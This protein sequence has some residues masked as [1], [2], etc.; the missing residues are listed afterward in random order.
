MRPLAARQAAGAASRSP[1][2]RSDALTAA[3]APVRPHSGRSAAL[4]AASA[5]VLPDSGRSDPLSRVTAPLRLLLLVLVALAGCA[6]AD[7]DPEV[8]RGE[9]LLWT[10]GCVA[11]HTLDGAPHVGPSLA[12]L[13]DER[14]EDYVLRAL[15]D[16]NI[17]LA[18]GFPPGLMPAYDLT[19][20][21][22]SALLAALAETRVPEQR[23]IVP[24][25]SACLLFLLLHLVLSARPIR[26][27]LVAR[28]GVYP[29]QGVYSAVVTALLAW[30][31][32]AWPDAPFVPLWDTPP[33]TRWVPLL[34][35]PFVL[36]GVIA[37]YTTPSPTVALM[38]GVVERPEP[39]RGAVKITRHPANLSMAAWGALH[40]VANGDLRSVVLMSSILLLGVL[41]SM[42]IDARRRKD[43]GEAWR[44]FEEQTSLV[45]FVAILRGEQRLRLADIGWWRIVLGL[46][47]YGLWLW[48]HGWV[49]GAD[50]WPF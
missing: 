25:A 29:Y 18:E 48:L 2:G 19:E 20:A 41:G 37:G 39:V 26:N 36:I 33:W 10:R 32:L 12:G 50:V 44:R 46:G 6:E 13:L 23:S 28:W 9:R 42:H 31:V 7:I 15:S 11:C 21:E 5:S 22:R 17:D 45:P 49:I 27:P 40:L 16:P 24:L 1:S 38:E 14:G 30:I 47:G 34:G 8:A 4:T 35:M 43:Y 3:S